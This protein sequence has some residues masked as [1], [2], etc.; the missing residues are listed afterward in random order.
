[1]SAMA[2]TNSVFETSTTG[3]RAKI[4]SSDP[5]ASVD[6]PEVQ[7]GQAKFVYNYFVTSERTEY[8]GGTGFITNSF[9]ATGRL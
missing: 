8:T 5:L 4:Y 7:M 9:S 6:A 2:D 1:M 3:A